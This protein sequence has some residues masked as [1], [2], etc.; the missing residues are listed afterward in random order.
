V[1]ALAFSEIKCSLVELREHSTI[2]EEQEVDRRRISLVSRR[3]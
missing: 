3:R 1:V 2:D